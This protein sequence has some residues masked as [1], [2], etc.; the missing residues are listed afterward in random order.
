MWTFATPIVA[1]W[2]IIVQTTGELDTMTV[3]RNVPLLYPILTYI[4]LVLFII[5]MPLLFNN[6]LVSLGILT[7]T[8]CF[9]S[10]HLFTQQIGMA[11]GE[12]EEERK[13]ASLTLIKMKVCF[14]LHVLFSNVS[15][16][17]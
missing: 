9:T 16:T 4:L 11:V 3:F 15:V 1:I 10:Y 14:L 17:S 6:F 8:V 7:T 13:K 5:A 2:N 12:T